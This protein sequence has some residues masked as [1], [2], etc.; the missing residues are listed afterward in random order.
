MR[1]AL[2]SKNQIEGKRAVMEALKADV[3]IQKLAIA[4]NI[5]RDGLIKDI[6]KRAY[7]KNI[8][9]SDMDAKQLTK[10]CN[11][12]VNQGIVAITKPYVYSPLSKIIEMSSQKEAS[13]VV[14][15]DHI[16]DT[17]NFGAI[18]RSAESVGCDGI[19]IPNARSADVNSTVYKTSAGAVTHISIAQVSNIARSIDE[20]KRSG[21]WICGA[22]EHAKSLVWDSD[23]TGRICLV[24]G[25]EEKGISD[26]VKKQLDFSCALP[27]AGKISSLNVA[28][29]STVFMYEWL[30]QNR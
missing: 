16:T 15:C 12:S 11:T 23:L 27:Q 10:I 28:Q 1:C 2:A 30:R 3:P 22:T 20:F 25:N 6:L 18:L 21:Y 19:V 4:N 24:L 14:V 5:N 17:H 29:A 7:S 8:P 26:L 13:L 9:V